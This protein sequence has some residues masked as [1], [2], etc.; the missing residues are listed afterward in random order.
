MVC[1]IEENSYVKSFKNSLVKQLR[2]SFNPLHSAAANGNLE[3]VNMF[4]N[5]FRTSSAPSSSEFL[6]KPWLQKD[7]FGCTPCHVFGLLWIITRI[8]RWK[9]WGWMWSCFLK[10]LIM[11]AKALGKGFDKISL[12]IL[13]SSPFNS[14]GLNGKNALH[15][16]TNCAGMYLISD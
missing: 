10:C 12:E 8:V 2:G 14:A 4:L 5:V 9:Y 15:L 3:I 1:L 11:R 13:R 7:K 6:P 16:L